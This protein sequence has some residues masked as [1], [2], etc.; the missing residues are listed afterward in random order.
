LSQGQRSSQAC[1]VWRLDLGP[2][3]PPAPLP[4]CLTCLPALRGFLADEWVLRNSFEH[5]PRNDTNAPGPLRSG[6]FV[7]LPP[8]RWCDLCKKVILVDEFGAQVCRRG[9]AITPTTALL[10]AVVGD[11]AG[12]S[13]RSKMEISYR[14]T[15]AGSAEVGRET[16]PRT[17]SAFSSLARRPLRSLRCQA[18][19][20]E[21]RDPSSAGIGRGQ[22]RERASVIGGGERPVDGRGR[23]RFGSAHRPPSPSV[24]SPNTHASTSNRLPL[25]A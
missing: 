19:P 1:I 22:W 9:W 21:P 4:T 20:A 24:Y 11:Y 23:A 7:S 25:S 5:P 17:R 18:T 3:L 10:H 2:R 16:S 14:F 13:A 12:A 6:A 15:P 8:G